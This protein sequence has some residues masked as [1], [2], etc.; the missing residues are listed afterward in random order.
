MEHFL[1][2]Q[3]RIH[4]C[5]VPKGLEVQFLQSLDL[6]RSDRLLVTA[7][8]ALKLSAPRLEFKRGSAGWAG[9]C[10][11]SAHSG[12]FENGLQLT[13]WIFWRRTIASTEQWRSSEVEL[14]KET[15]PQ[16]MSLGD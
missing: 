1:D 13:A 9:K 11:W 8:G 16:I 5:L 3:A 10:L 4:R 14:L 6:G 12:S 2:F 15:R 7:V